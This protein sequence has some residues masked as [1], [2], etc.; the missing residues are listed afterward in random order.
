MCKTDA[1]AEE[2]NRLLLAE[3]LRHE[4]G[5]D[6]A[7]AGSSGESGPMAYVLEFEAEVWDLYRYRK[8][9]AHGNRAFYNGDLPGAIEAFEQAEP[10]WRGP[11]LADVQLGP[12]LP[13][14]L[15]DWSSQ[16]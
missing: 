5:D 16:G 4:P 12:L 3:I 15:R 7:T 6:A 13:R 11:V 1:L 8:A 14:R 9:E 2:A 10:L